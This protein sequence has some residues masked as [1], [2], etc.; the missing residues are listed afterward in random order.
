MVEA[1]R[2]GPAERPDPRGV[3]AV[4]LACAVLDVHDGRHAERPSVDVRRDEHRRRV[5]AGSEPYRLAP[6][7]P[8]ARRPRADLL[9][10]SDELVHDRGEVRPVV[11][12]GGVRVDHNGQ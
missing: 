3:A 4:G 1:A 11:G 2:A 10:T 5:M 9:T 12:E 8:T 7:F 6:R